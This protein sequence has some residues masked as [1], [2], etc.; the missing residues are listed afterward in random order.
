MQSL[1]KSAWRGAATL[2]IAITMAVPLSNGAFAE[3]NL[4]VQQ[5]STLPEVTIKALQEALNK[6]GIPVAVGGVLD[7][8]TR[9]AI[10]KYQSQHHLPVTGEAD[11]ATLAKLGVA[12]RQSAGPTQSG[13]QAASQSGTTG[14]AGATPAPGGMPMGGMMN[15]P[16]MQGQMHAMMQMMQGMMQMMQGQVQPGQSGPGQM[17]PGQMGP[18]QMGP[19]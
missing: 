4:S 1:S 10:R 17:Q 6:Q 13:S 9:E 11:P 7:Q 14:Q 8:A 15:C 5:A 12:A 19:R 2:L 16:M 3:T 18:G